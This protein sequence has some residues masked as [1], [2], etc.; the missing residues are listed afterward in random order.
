VASFS[1][2]HVVSGFPYLHVVP[3]SFVQSAETCRS[4][5]KMPQEKAIHYDKINDK[6]RKRMM[7]TTEHHTF[8][9]FHNLS[10]SSNNSI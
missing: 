7:T 3:S 9:S 10:K 4:Y 2:I 6:M 8:N 5:S 1:R